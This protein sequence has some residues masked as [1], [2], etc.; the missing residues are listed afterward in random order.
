MRKPRSRPVPLR[1]QQHPEPQPPPAA[2]S[3][4]AADPAREPTRPDAKAARRAA[5][6]R[7]VIARAP[8]A[9]TALPETID[10]MV[11]DE[12][13]S[14]RTSLCELLEDFGF[15]A[16]SA[17]D[18]AEVAKLLRVGPF[19]AVFLHVV[20][21]GDGHSLAAELCRLVKRPFGASGRT[22]ALIIVAGDTR[23]SD[24]VRATL[25][26]ADEFLVKPLG[27]GS[28]ARALQACG[29]ALPSDPRRT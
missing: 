26:G 25:A 18:P 23:P 13:D 19:A 29:I 9:N 21:D 6:R 15:C 11:L 7:A 27:R 12:D 22:A 16:L 4:A 8:A 28:V 17:R 10:V 2:W 3:N 1:Q 5:V 20:L 14:A 24:R